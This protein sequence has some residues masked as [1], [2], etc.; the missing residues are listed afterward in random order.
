M[1]RA[2]TWRRTCLNGS[3]TDDPDPFY[4]DC[5]SPDQTSLLGKNIGDLLTEKQISWG[6]F[7]GGFTPS[8]A[9][10]PEL[11]PLPPFLRFVGPRRSVWTALLSRPTFHTTIPS[12]IMRAPQIAIIFSR[13]AS[14]KLATTVPQTINT[15]SP[16]SG[17]QLSPETFQQSAT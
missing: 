6:W 7:E 8:A 2:A 12:N 14:R 5:G 3:I 15:T 4:D 10:V 13:R 17:R 1:T 16:I 9:Y 11:E